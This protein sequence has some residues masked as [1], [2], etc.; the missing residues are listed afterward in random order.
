VPE[1]ALPRLDVEVIGIDQRAVD[2]EDYR[3]DQGTS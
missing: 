1:G 2:I 3:F